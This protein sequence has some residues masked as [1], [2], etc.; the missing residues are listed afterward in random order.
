MQT[1]NQHITPKQAVKGLAIASN[2]SVTNGQMNL[3]YDRFEPT[4]EGFR[5]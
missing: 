4:L 5:D 1:L 3:G 2:W